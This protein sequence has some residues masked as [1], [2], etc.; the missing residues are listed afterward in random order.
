MATEAKTSAPQDAARLIQDV[1]AEVGW[2][3]DPSD[4]ARQVH[5]LNIGLPCEDEFSVVCAWLGQCQLIHK[6]DQQQVPVASRQQ[7]QVPDLLAMFSSQT[8]KSP[9]L[10]EVK[11]NTKQALSFRPDYLA[12][13]QNYASLLRLPL[14]IAWKFHSLW[15]LFEAHHLQMAKKNYNINLGMAEQENVL[16]V[17]AGDVSYKLG[18]G[19]GIHLSLRKNKLLK[20]EDMGDKSTEDW[21]VVIESV[22]FSDYEGGIRT[23]L[24]PEVQSLFASCELEEREEHT[25]THIHQHIVAGPEPQGMQFAHS[26]LVRLLNWESPDEKTPHWRTLLRKEQ[27]T[28]NIRDFTGT[29]NTALN[30]KIVSHIFHQVPH[31]EPDFLQP[32][33]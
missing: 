18:E 11:S 1:L 16:G 7:F 15:V 2:S 25:P 4:I 19:A 23:D 33:E 6:L 12:R 30:Q 8:T 13:L 9:V 21:Q 26:A 32:D 3:A 5:R 17:L 14:L 28:K 31:T 22:A 27:V 29:L 20:R 24:S 10:I